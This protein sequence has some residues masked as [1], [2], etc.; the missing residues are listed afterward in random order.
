M[1][2]T[3][4]WQEIFCTH[5]LISSLV[6]TQILKHQMWSALGKAAS[7]AH[8]IISRNNKVKGLIEYNKECLEHCLRWVKFVSNYALHKLYIECLEHYTRWPCS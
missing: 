4:T 3:I 1:Y 7:Y 5:I 8:G 2:V 6:C